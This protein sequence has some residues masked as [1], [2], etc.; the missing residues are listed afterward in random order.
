MSIHNSYRAENDTIFDF[1]CIFSSLVTENQINQSTNKN[2]SQIVQKKL[3]GNDQ[4]KIENLDIFKNKY[5]LAIEAPTIQNKATLA[6]HYL[7]CT[8]AYEKYT[9]FDTELTNTQY[10]YILS[11]RKIFEWAIRENQS[12]IFEGFKN[13]K[14]KKTLYYQDPLSGN[15]LAYA[16]SFRNK[17]PIVDYFCRNFPSFRERE[18]RHSHSPIFVAATSGNLEG[19]QTLLRYDE[20][21]IEEQDD[22][23]NNLLI[24]TILTKRNDVARYIMENYPA[25]ISQKKNRKKSSL[26]FA[27]EHGNKEMARLLLEKNANSIH[28]CT[29]HNR[30]CAHYAAVSGDPDLIRLIFERAPEL[31]EKKDRQGETPLQ[32]AIKQKEFEAVK[33]IVELLKKIAT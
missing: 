9:N 28:D 12:D 7:Q 24:A 23:G 27:F 26:H 31:F 14:S 6:K 3:K 21:L 18:N 16:L 29:S 1:I 30:S 33:L 25:L 22:N 15:L 32:V 2:I 8:G 5:R 19:L 11:I 20:K 13:G 4:T 10:N 17:L